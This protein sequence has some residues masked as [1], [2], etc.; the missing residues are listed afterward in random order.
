MTDT[1]DISPT[2]IELF[3]ACQ[4]KFAFTYL[5]GR[6]RP[7]PG[8]GAVM[9]TLC[10]SLVE[11][12][13]N[14]GIPDYSYD[15]AD[16]Q[17]RQAAK[18][19][20]AVIPFLPT[21]GPG[22]VAEG[23]VSVSIHGV[24][25]AGRLDWSSPVEVGDLKTCS[26]FKYVPT[27]D[28]LRQGAQPVIYSLAR[29]GRECHWLYAPT[30]G[31]EPRP[32]RFQ[33]DMTA[34]LDR[35]MADAYLIRDLW[36]NRPDPNSLPANPATC[37][38][39]GGCP[40][41][42]ECGESPITKLGWTKGEHEMSIADFLKKIEAKKTEDTGEA[43]KTDPAPPLAPLPPPVAPSP[44]EVQTEARVDPPT[45]IAAKPKGRP[46]KV[47]PPESQVQP[48]AAP[49]ADTAKPILFLFVNCLPTKGFA[50]GTP[51]PFSEMVARASARIKTVDN[52]EHWSA[53]PY[54]TGGGALT[55]CVVD[56]VKT[57]TDA[58]IVIDT[59]TPEGMHVANALM[60][61]AANVVR[62]L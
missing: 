37:D 9:G 21:P 32:L 52:V 16:V 34:G 13:L 8:P 30:S 24:T 33:A 10:H 58:V 56:E 6:P 57:L 28:Q 3:R 36:R 54:G 14:T 19:L 2:Q 31:K 42:S 53:L 43:P 12:Y 29:P 1:P 15:P 41:K 61:L 26:S 44:T 20:A 22:V 4:R 48:E 46:R 17:R 27:I 50:E 45:P 38:A 25:L 40:F 59:R 35:V 7:A 47:T 60:V 39:Y 55:K 62:G 18:V 23:K 51:V 5:T 11:A 49:V